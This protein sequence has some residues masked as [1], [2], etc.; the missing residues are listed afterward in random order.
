[1]FCAGV[2]AEIRVYRACCENLRT[3]VRLRVWVRAHGWPAPLR[4]LHT[5]EAG[6]C[7]ENGQTY[8][9]FGPKGYKA[10]VILSTTRN[11]WSKDVSRWNLYVND[12]Y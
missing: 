4:D 1:M 5:S 11:G 12:L 3:R 8:Y 10:S 7:R 2:A 6:S 9:R